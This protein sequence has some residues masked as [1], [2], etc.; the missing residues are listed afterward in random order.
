MSIDNPLPFTYRKPF[1]HRVTAGYDFTAPG[2]TEAVGWREWIDGDPVLLADYDGELELKDKNQQALAIT[3]VSG[4]FG[5]L[6][7]PKGVAHIQ[8]G[9]VFAIDRSHKTIVCYSPAFKN[10]APVWRPLWQTEGLDEDSPYAL[11]QPMDLMFSSKN[12]LVVCDAGKQQVI[13]FQWPTLQVKHIAQFCD[14]YPVAVTQG[15]LHSY[16]VALNPLDTAEENTDARL[17][18]IDAAFQQRQAIELPR[19]HIGHA[20]ALTALEDGRILLLRHGEAV[21]IDMAS[22]TLH[23]DAKVWCLDD[24]RWQSSFWR[25]H[26]IKP[27]ANLAELG[28]ARSTVPALVLQ[29]GELYQPNLKNPGCAA[30]WLEASGIDRKGFIVITQGQGASLSASRIAIVA[31]PKRIRIKKS[32]RLISP[33]IESDSDQFHWD[34]LL[35]QT[36]VLTNTSL[37]IQTK[38]SDRLLS[39]NEIIGDFQQPWSTAIRLDANSE[40]QVL[41][42]SLPGRYLYLSIEFYGDGYTSTHIDAVNIE[43]PR[44]SSLQWLPPVYHQDK[45]SKHFLDRL[46]SYFD[47][48]FDQLGYQADHFARYL[49][50]F[51]VPDEDFLNWLASWF[52]WDF[53]PQTSVEQKREIISQLM[54]FYRQRGTMKGLKRLLR[55]YTGLAEPHPQIIE[56]FAF[57]RFLSAG[58][59]LALAGKKYSLSELSADKAH[60]FTLLLPQALATSDENKE[61]FYQLV[62]AQKPA[63]TQFKIEFFDSQ[64][65]VG[66]QSRIGVDMIIGRRQEA[67]LNDNEL[68]VSTVLTR[69]PITSFH[70]DRC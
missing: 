64:V 45:E 68:G 60:R 32:R 67:I 6:T 40:P 11:Q 51:T 22:M 27:I 29:N 39:D 2:T 28:D 23:A 49:S 30:A 37:V 25:V 52:N 16:I 42:Q 59:E 17:V 7:T 56:H 38:T 62:N 47:V 35:L 15:S 33:P 20:D 34:R 66:C 43:G 3:E 69:S 21:P 50:P 19:H 53:F 1:Y 65:V 5:G 63:H 10:K 4:S 8:N 18:R 57:E 54:E 14:G 9:I 44:Q 31:A 36:Q 24:W 70:N 12:E 48:V 58:V 46:L 26:D 41:I 13:W 55:W 61:R